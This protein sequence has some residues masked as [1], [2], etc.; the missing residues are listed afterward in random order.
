MAVS[1]AD[2][3]AKTVQATNEAEIAAAQRDRDL[4]QAGFKA[5]T[6]KARALADMAGNI[7]RAA[8]EQTLRVAEA[9][10]DAAAA[11]ANIKVQEQE[12]LRKAKELEV[13]VI[14]PAE[15]QRQAAVIQAEAAKQRQ[16]LDAQATAEVLSTT[17]Q[18]KK[19]AAVLEGEGEA[20]ATRAKLIAKAEGDAAAA[21]ETLKAQADGTEALNKAMAQMSD[22]AKLLLVLDRLPT[23][24]DKGGEAGA[25]VLGSMFGPIAAGVGS[26]DS[27]RIVDMGGS[28]NGVDK[29][30]GVVSDTV[31]QV[32]AQLKSRGVDIKGLLA[33]A[34]VKTDGLDFLL[35]GTAPSSPA[36]S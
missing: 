22:S 10:R 6:E 8:Q 21:R 12:A 16:I 29:M 4:K 3:E 31:F 26:I 19:N 14:R 15:A 2:K 11:T 20:A 27:I 13:T 17:A 7:V 18:A 9:D 35:D 28:G 33:V 34:G 23:L 24:L 36:S 1:N 32:L 30:S 25:K 5:E